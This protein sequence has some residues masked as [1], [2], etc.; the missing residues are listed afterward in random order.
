MHMG[1]DMVENFEQAEEG[2]EIEGRR[3]FSCQDEA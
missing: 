1:G 3:I 2:R